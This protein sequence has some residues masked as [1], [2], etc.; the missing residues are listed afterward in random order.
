MAFK[1][2]RSDKNVDLCLFIMGTLR[3]A[4]ISADFLE[5][6]KNAYPQKP[7]ALCIIGVREVYEPFFRIAEEVGI[8]VFTSVRRAVNGLAALNRYSLLYQG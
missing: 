3:I 6:I 4:D 8:P 7:M 5:D 1:A 2:M